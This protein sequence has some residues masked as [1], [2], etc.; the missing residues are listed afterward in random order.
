MD[1]YEF[2]LQM[3]IIDDL[4]IEH[5]NEIIMSNLILD[6]SNLKLSLLA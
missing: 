5:P 4:I 3:S 6:N 1:I 2:F